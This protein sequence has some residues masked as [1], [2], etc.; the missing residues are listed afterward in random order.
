M[1]NSIL[2]ALGGASLTTT[3]V[4]FGGCATTSSPESMETSAATIRAAQEVGSSSVPQ[5]ALHV[6][7]ARE[8]SERAKELLK[9]GGSDERAQAEL[10][11]ARAQA[12]ADL[13]LALARED[14]D[15]DAAKQAV[16]DVRTLQAR[17][18]TALATARL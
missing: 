3:L 11:F 16:N 5:A 13:A 15:R 9:A 18:T 1:K 2:R 14:V 10:L 6:Q 12:D 17:H 7:L 4:L 8:Q